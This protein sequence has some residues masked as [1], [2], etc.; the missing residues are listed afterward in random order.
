MIRGLA[1]SYF[2]SFNHSLGVTDHI[3]EKPDAPS[4]G[5]NSQPSNIGHA[6]FELYFFQ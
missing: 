4:T 3:Q 5:T 6:C 2:I 1:L